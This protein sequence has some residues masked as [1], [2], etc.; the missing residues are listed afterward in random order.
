MGVGWS[1]DRDAS[2]SGLVARACSRSSG[3]DRAVEETETL[4]ESFISDVLGRQ[5]LLVTPVRESRLG[6]AQHHPQPDLSV[7][8]QWTIEG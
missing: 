5:L 6:A 2:Q 7:V 4:I 3:G 1:A 8:N